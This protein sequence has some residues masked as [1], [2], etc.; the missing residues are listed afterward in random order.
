ME[1][2]LRINNVAADTTRTQQ[3]AQWNSP[4]VAGGEL[5]N[6]Y[7]SNIWPTQRYDGFAQ[8]SQANPVQLH[9]LDMSGRISN[10]RYFV[11]GAYTADAGG[12]RGF[13]GQLQRRARVNLDY[14]IR[15]NWNVSLSSLFNRGSI[16]Q[17]GTGN[18]FGQLLRGAPA[19]TDY[20]RRD[21]LGRYLVRGGGSGFR[22]T[23][24]GG[25][26]L[27]Y[28]TEST[29]DQDVSTRYQASLSSTY[30]PADWLS[31]EGLY[32]YDNRQRLNTFYQIKGSR[33]TSLAP[34]HQPG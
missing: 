2:M 31:I 34:E 12:L 7:Q 18:I 9:S 28:V 20:L 22:P 19:G 16:D 1:E 33:T 15:P 10:V 24:N 3:N 29:F 21:T 25:G 26:S 8:V 5:L 30:T 11:S 6:V 27:L 14:D 4:A 32:S 13:N 17:R 23:A